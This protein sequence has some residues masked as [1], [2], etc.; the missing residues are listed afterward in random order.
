MTMR[1]KRRLRTGRKC[2]WTENDETRE[3]K[4]EDRKEIYDERKNDVEGEEKDEDS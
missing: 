3:D 2:T 4:Y 1:R